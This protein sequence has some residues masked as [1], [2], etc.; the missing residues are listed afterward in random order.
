MYAYGIERLAATVATN[1]VYPVRR[2]GKF[3]RHYT[4]GRWWDSLY[5]WDSGFIGL[6]L[7]ELEPA[8]SVDN[9][10][11]YLTNADDDCAFIFHGSPLPVQ[12]WLTWRNWSPLTTCCVPTRPTPVSACRSE[13]QGT[14]VRR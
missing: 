3:I 11:A 8:R 2:R 9:L 13:P 12:T 5:T 1:A 10:A 6:G 14:A 4:P 7:L